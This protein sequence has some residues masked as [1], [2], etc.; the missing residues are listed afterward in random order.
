MPTD[1]QRTQVTHTP[2][3]E[4]ALEVA[5]RRWPA[6]RSTGR[7]LANLIVEGAKAIEAYDELVA[8]ER[9]QMLEDI[10]G[11]YGHMYGP[12]YID[13]IRETQ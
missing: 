3:V 12:G 13:R 11:T 1:L 8:A 10:A 6:E 9:R 4:A 2:E 7:L 5:R